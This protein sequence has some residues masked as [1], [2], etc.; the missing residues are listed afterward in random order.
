MVSPWPLEDSPSLGSI[1]DDAI[2]SPGVV[3]VAAAVEVLSPVE[4]VG[5]SAAVRGS[6][7]VLPGSEVELADPI[8]AE[9]SAVVEQPPSTSAPTRVEDR[10]WSRCMCFASRANLYPAGHGEASMI[11]GP[12]AGDRRRLRC[13]G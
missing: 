4:V 8:V 10:R 2:V 13:G 11:S 6:P 7:E 1:V 3:E 9:L 5:A 12:S